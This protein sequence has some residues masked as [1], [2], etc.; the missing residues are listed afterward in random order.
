MKFLLAPWIL[1]SLLGL[2]VV[3]FVQFAIFISYVR[4]RHPAVYES[5]GEPGMFGHGPFKIIGYVF[6]R[7]HRIH[8]DPRFS[9]LCDTM[10]VSYSAFIAMFAYAYYLQFQPG[11]ATNP[12]R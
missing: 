4:K 6:R 11:S 1:Y 3:W 12:T 2:T 8:N 7:G 5:L 10:M 9:L